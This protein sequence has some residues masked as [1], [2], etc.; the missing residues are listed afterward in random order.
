MADRGNG[1]RRARCIRLPGQGGGRNIE[2]HNRQC[3]R[4]SVSGLR[5]RHYTHG[6]IQS[7]QMSAASDEFR[8]GDDIECGQSKLGAPA[9][10]LDC[11]VWTD[12]SRLAQR[13]SQRRGGGLAHLLVLYSIIADLR[14][15][16]RYF[17]DS[18]SKRLT[19]IC[20]RISRLRGDSVVLSFLAQTA[21]ICS[22]CAVASGGVR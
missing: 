11:Q 4:K 5:R 3:V 14:I 8:I 15:S 12:A 9:P 18:D 10:E 20:S 22:P 17:F 7:E 19:N 13:Q 1:G 16:S 2:R 6:N 21:N